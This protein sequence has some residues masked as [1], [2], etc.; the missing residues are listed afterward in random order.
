MITLRPSHKR[1][2]A[3]HGWLDTYHTFSFADYFDPAHMGFRA[4]RVLNEDRVQAGMG[5]GTHPH[6]DMEILTYVLA[7]ELEHKDSMGNGS[8]IHAGE[9]QVM[10]AGT[11]I[12]HSEYNH[13]E[14]QPVHLVQIWIKP[15]SKG[16]TPSYGQ[17]QFTNEEKHGRLCLIASQDGREKSL[18]INQ[19]AN[20]FLAAFENGTKLRH[21]V[22]AG[23]HM[24]V[25]VLGGELMINGVL[26]NAGDGAAISNETAIEINSKNSGEVMLFDLN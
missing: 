1:G 21:Q 5:F 10:T 23:R 3:D 11:G 9:V 26:M 8:V 22:R 4:L 20:V 2:H 12:T 18:K 6:Q 19:D 16:L 24:W 15:H 13:S 17:R 7:G 25:Q 14:T